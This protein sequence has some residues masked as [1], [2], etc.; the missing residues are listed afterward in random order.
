MLLKLKH[1]CSKLYETELL[2]VNVVSLHF[3]DAPEY[4]TIGTYEHS[5]L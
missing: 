4:L 2:C 5:S 1:V 3:Q